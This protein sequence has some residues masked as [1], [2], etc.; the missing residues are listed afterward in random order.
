MVMD[1]VVSPQ[2]GSAPRENTIR[3]S[4]CT[5]VRS[6]DPRASTGSASTKEERN[7]PSVSSDDLRQPAACSGPHSRPQRNGSSLVLAAAS[8]SRL[9]ARERRRSTSRATNVDEER[10]VGRA[11]SGYAAGARRRNV[12]RVATSRIISAGR[13]PPT[14]RTAARSI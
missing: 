14:Q 5:A 6:V 4:V 11:A 13:C 3:P 2:N 8:S 10:N 7:G 12:A 9:L 1:V